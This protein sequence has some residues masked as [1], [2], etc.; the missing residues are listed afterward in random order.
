MNMVKEDRLA[1]LRKGRFYKLLWPIDGVPAGIYR[2][3]GSSE[4]GLE[5]SSGSEV[6]MAVSCRDGAPVMVPVP[7]RKGV[8]AVGDR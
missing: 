6:R 7:Y 5:L 8:Q 4:R 2:Y 3:E 1:H